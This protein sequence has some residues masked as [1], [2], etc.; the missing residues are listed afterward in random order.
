M[1]R[2]LLLLALPLLP[3]CADAEDDP[4]EF[5]CG[6]QGGRCD[7]ETEICIVGD[8]C[9]TCAPRPPTCDEQSACECLP[10]ASDPVWDT[11]RCVDKGTCEPVDGGLVV[12]C[13][14]PQ[15]WGCG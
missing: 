15:G 9:S 10:P 14:E 5:A 13:E 7:R 3:A 2:L 1:R 6:D 8:D 12:T 11:R 4:T